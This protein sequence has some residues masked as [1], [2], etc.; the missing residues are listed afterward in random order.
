MLHYCFI[1]HTRKEETETKSR[2][3]LIIVEGILTLYNEK[4]YE[5]MDNKFFV[6]T[7]QY[8]CFIRRLIRYVRKRRRT[9]YSVISQWIRTVGLGYK[10]YIWP[11][12]ENA[13]Y[14]IKGDGNI[15]ESIKPIVK[16]IKDHFKII[17]YNKN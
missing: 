12:R 9:V 3:D 10:N 14:I 4:I 13:D 7:P 15:K 8:K 5:L 11:S 6:Y 1:K 2:A 17:N 16:V